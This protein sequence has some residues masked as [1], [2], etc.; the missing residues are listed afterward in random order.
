MTG[1]G[2]LSVSDAASTVFAWMGG[3]H[4]C[5]GVEGGTKISYLLQFELTCVCGWIVSVRHTNVY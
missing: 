5:K 1:E 4:L 3:R 2:E